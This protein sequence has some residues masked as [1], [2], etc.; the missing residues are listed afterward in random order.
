MDLVESDCIAMLGKD[1]CVNALAGGK[2]IE[3]IKSDTY[4]AENYLLSDDI[5]KWAITDSINFSEYERD[6]LENS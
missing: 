3:L 5:L 2:S 4:K 6:V 1:I